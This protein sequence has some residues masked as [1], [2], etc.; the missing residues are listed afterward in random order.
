MIVPV[1][2]GERP[3]TP[4]WLWEQCNEHRIALPKLILLI[5]AR[6]AGDDIRAGMFLSVATLSALAASLIAL[7]GRLPGGTR[8]S[9]A[10][11]PL[12]LLHPG[13]AANLLWSIQLSVV[14]PTALGTAFLVPIVGRASWP[15]PATA[16][17]AGLGMGCCRSAAG[18]GWRSSPPGPLAARGGLGR[19]PD[20]EARLGAPRGL[21]SPWRRCPA[22]R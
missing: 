7:A 3:V 15:G 1:L 18:R 9:D 16:V 5:A 13:H 6:L 11:F 22:S 20:R 8:P 4:G 2:A 10:F 19:G 14:L 17:L 12:L 21:R